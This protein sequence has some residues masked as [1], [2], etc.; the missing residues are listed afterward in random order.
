MILCIYNKKDGYGH[1]FFC[2]YKFLIQNSFFASKMGKS[3]SKFLKIAGYHQ[4][5]IINLF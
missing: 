2:W 1:V 3:W 4:K 5:H